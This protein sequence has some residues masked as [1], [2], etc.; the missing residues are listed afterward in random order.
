MS[1]MGD[2]EILRLQPGQKRQQMYPLLHAQFKALFE[3]ENNRIANLANAASL[4]YFGCGF[5]WVGFYL[6]DETTRQLVL[7]PFHGPV[8]CTRIPWGTGVCGTAWKRREHIVVPDVNTF[9]GHIACSSASRSE[10]VGCIVGGK[11]P[12]APVV[13]VLDID[14]VILADFDETDQQ[15]LGRVV[16]L[17]SERWPSWT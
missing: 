17:I 16:E 1:M 2:I 3:G 4:L 12:H 14:S 10:W 9:E 13:A 15:E 6:V 5:W 8:A 7:G 11:E